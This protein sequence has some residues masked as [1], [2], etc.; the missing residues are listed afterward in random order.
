V[1]CDS[2]ST[3]LIAKFQEYMEYDDLRYFAMKS[4]LELL[5]SHSDVS[6]LSSICLSLSYRGNDINQAF[7]RFSVEALLT[8]CPVHFYTWARNFFP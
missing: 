1:Q 4:I 8:L 5:K 6:Y 7:S 3:D 2:E